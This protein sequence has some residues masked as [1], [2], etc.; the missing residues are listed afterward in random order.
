MKTHDSM[1]GYHG[2]NANYAANRFELFI[3]CLLLCLYD[4]FIY[5]VVT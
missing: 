5:S 4:K 1:S 2:V 3:S